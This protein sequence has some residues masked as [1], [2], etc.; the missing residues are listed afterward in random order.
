[1]KSLLFILI[2]AEILDGKPEITSRLVTIQGIEQ[3][4]EMKIIDSEWGYLGTGPIEI[5]F[6]EDNYGLKVFSFTSHEEEPREFICEEPEELEYIQGEV[7]TG[8]KQTGTFVL[9][10]I[11]GVTVEDPW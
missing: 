6:S 8:K 11:T 3:Q 2:I 5:S 7:Y 4:K 9:R 10:K 1:M